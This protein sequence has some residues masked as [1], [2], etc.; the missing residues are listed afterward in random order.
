MSQTADEYVVYA[1]PACG[2]RVFAP[3]GDVGRT[4][5]CPLCTHPHT[6]GGAVSAELG[7]ERRGAKRVEPREGQVALEPGEAS[8]LQPRARI[9]TVLDLSETGVAFSFPGLPSSRHLSGYAPPDLK[10]GTRLRLELEANGLNPCWVTAVVRRVVHTDDPRKWR[11]GM[12]FVELTPEIKAGLR[13]AVERA[14]QAPD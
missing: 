6:V 4:G 5:R 2:K 9:C 10:L 14:A 12:E 7:V 13:V 11:V 3:Q 8:P 1:C